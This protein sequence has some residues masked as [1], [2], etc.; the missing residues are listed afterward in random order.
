MNYKYINLHA[1]LPD[2]EYRWGR[3][4]LREPTQYNSCHDRLSALTNTWTTALE[5]ASSPTRLQVNF[6]SFERSA[7]NPRPVA[8]YGNITCKKYEPK[9]NKCQTERSADAVSSNLRSLIRPNRAIGDQW[10]CENLMS[11]S[12]CYAL[13]RVADST[14]SQNQLHSQ[15]L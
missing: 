10:G 11:L 12:L 7:S 1:T 3:V 2:E 13:N 5:N 6:L 8:N 15:W 14:S 4:Q 9:A